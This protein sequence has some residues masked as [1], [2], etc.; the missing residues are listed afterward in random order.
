MTLPKSSEKS[1][2]DSD[3]PPGQQ[4]TI[5]QAEAAL[6]DVLVRKSKYTGLETF[7]EKVE[8][9]VGIKHVSWDDFYYSGKQNRREESGNASGDYFSL[10]R[11][12]KDAIYAA[13]VIHREFGETSENGTKIGPLFTFIGTGIEPTRGEVARVIEYRDS[14][15]CIRRAVIP[16]TVIHQG[17]H[18]LAG[19]L[20]A[21]GFHAP[22]AKRA[23][24]SLQSLLARITGPQITIAN[25]TGWVTGVDKAAFVLPNKIVG[26]I[27]NARVVADS[28]AFASIKI[29]AAGT[30]EDW[31]HGVA[32][33]AR[34]NS[35]LTLAICAALT[36]PL[37]RFASTI[38]PTILHFFADSSCGKTSTLLAAGSVWGGA[39]G[40]PLGYGQSWNA[41]SNFILAIAAAHTDTLLTLDELRTAS[42]PDVVKAAYTLA[43]GQGRGRLT[44]DAQRRGIDRFRTMVLSSG[45]LTLDELERQA[46]GSKR[47]AFAGAEMRLPSIPADARKG[48]G[49]FEDIHKLRGKENGA[50]RFADALQSAARS[51]YGHAGP[52]FIEELVEEIKEVEED[53]VRKEIA[54]MVREFTESIDLDEGADDAVKR[55]LRT[56]GLIAA[57]GQFACRW[58][59]LPMSE[60]DV[61]WGVATCFNAWVKARGGARSK[62]A[63]TAL[64]E[65]RDFVQQNVG[66]FIATNADEL[67]KIANIAGYVETKGDNTTYY[68]LPPVWKHEILTKA[69]RANLIEA[70][71]QLDLL[72]R[73]PG[74][75]DDT[76]VKKIRM[77]GKP[78]RAYAVD[79]AILELTDQGTIEAPA[80]GNSKVAYLSEHQDSTAS[81]QLRM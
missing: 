10:S 27:G 29:A 69:P 25:A 61:V 8:K 9:H 68:I 37:L 44:K 65:L 30:F 59:I 2:P 1:A 4:P 42:A 54:A 26:H 53:E 66:R 21:K 60:D 19:Y 5:Q 81:R 45:E 16:L 6:D 79:G 33:K 67:P 31:Q 70:L 7:E 63:H 75:S 41:T 34:G 14:F 74:S 23:R 77:L 52:R 58:K 12:T 38:T 17:G 62:T 28:S 22:A 40:D 50:A 51:N 57:A 64:I 3:F 43:G 18:Y 80:P 78:V 35:R 71:D 56:F 48:L 49:I 24:E 72:K 55:L 32:A 11:V 76:V 15:G 20:A 73:K 47:Q 13:S 46:A 39:D 36:S